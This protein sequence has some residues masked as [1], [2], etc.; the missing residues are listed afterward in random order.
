V[1]WLDGDSSE[2]SYAISLYKPDYWD[3]VDIVGVVNVGPKDVSTT[4]GHKSAQT[5]AFFPVRMQHIHEKIAR[6]KEYMEKKDFQ[7]FGE[8]V[9]AEALELH[10]IMLTSLPGLIYWHPGTIRVMKYVQKWRSEGLPVY[11]TI[12]TGQDIHLICEKKNADRLEELLRDVPEVRQTIRN[13]AAVGTR[14]STD[15]LF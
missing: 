6:I 5:S 8:L 9:E 1:E 12:N 2:T 13:T 14:L 10:A 15:H 7:A 3:L 4:E 11:F